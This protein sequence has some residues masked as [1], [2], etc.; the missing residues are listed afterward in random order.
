MSVTFSE[1]DRQFLRSCGVVADE[2]NFRLEALWLNWSRANTHRDFSPCAGCGVK[3]YEQHALDCK[4]GAAM[5]FVDSTLGA[6]R[7]ALAQRIAKHQ[8]PA[9]V[10]V[11][12]DAARLELIRLAL[13][14]LL[15]ADC[16]Q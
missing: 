15:A 4:R 14:R 3:T 12:P 6:D 5:A 16:E 7:L 9:R 11:A 8:A 1:N 2:E 13:R 10:R